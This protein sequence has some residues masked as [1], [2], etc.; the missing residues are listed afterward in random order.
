MARK[1]K[2][3]YAKYRRQNP[4]KKKRNRIF[5]TIVIMI[6]VA[7]VLA[8]IGLF[9]EKHKLEAEK[10]SIEKQ[11]KQ[12]EERTKSLEKEK[13]YRNSNAYIEKIAREKF[14]LFYPD[15]YVLEED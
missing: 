9:Q 6:L 14:G 1:K 7:M 15:E 2:D 5:G 10:A 3:K 11:I 13:K 12:E 8:E 4:E